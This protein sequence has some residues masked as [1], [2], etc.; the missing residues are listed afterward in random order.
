LRR[1]ASQCCLRKQSMFILRFGTKHSNWQNELFGSEIKTCVTSSIHRANRINN[2]NASST[3]SLNIYGNVFEKIRI[4]QAIIEVCSC[5][6]CC[7]GKA[8]SITYSGFVFVVTSMQCACAIL[9]SVPC[10]VLQYFSTLSHKQH[11]FSKK[12]KKSYWTQNACFDFLY[13]FCLNRFSF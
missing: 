7:S 5:N 10:P 2:T 13:N 1:Q 9:P 4:G 8:I 6:H 12:K 11:E 3:N